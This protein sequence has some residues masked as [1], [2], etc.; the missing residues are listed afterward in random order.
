LSN[1][2]I[3]GLESGTFRAIH[4]PEAPSFGAFWRLARVKVRG[5]C[6]LREMN[7]IGCRCGIRP[8]GIDRL[9]AKIAR[10]GARMGKPRGARVVVIRG[11]GSLAAEPV[12]DER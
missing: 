9:A 5:E 6:Q 8:F 3:F 12:Q 1:T 10:G 2:R 11:G 4:R 7:R